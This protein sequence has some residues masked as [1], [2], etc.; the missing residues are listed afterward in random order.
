[1]SLAVAATDLE[2]PQSRV[3]ALSPTGSLRRCWGHGKWRLTKKFK[4]DK[5]GNTEETDGLVGDR[6]ERALDEG[7]IVVGGWDHWP[8]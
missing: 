8:T 5:K 6:E 1:M 4:D 2:P 3:G 7:V